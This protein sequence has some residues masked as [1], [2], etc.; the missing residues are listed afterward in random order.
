MLYISQ[1]ELQNCEAEL[2]S[3]S[4]ELQTLKTGCGVFKQYVSN[5]VKQSSIKK[6]HTQ[7]PIPENQNKETLGAGITGYSFLYSASVKRNTIII[8]VVHI[9]DIQVRLF[10]DAKNHVRDNNPINS[11]PIE[12]TLSHTHS[13]LQSSDETP[14]EIALFRTWRNFQSCNTL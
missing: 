5:M 2:S 8:Y 11:F 9:L 14:N 12:E 13:P 3:K 10:S 7:S 6:Y 1:I 4:F